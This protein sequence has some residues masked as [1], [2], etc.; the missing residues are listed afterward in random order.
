MS[1]AN[2]Q[3]PSME[4]ILA[5]IRRIISDDGDEPAPTSG[6]A[7]QAFA[8][9]DDD[10]LEL[11]VPAMASQAPPI[12]TLAPEPE[13]DDLETFSFDLD[14]DLESAPEPTAAPIAQSV[15]E[16]SLV[17]T[18]AQAAAASAFDRLAQTVAMPL[19]TRTLED[20]VRELLRPLLKAWLDENLLPIVQAKVDEEVER[21]ARRR[22]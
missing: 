12:Q 5:S 3:E 4:E 18:L 19:D 6:A 8:P 17:N 11:N 21:I 16:P 1:E 22:F 2:A 13:D 10:V 9:E 14:D 15:P 20:V 7:S